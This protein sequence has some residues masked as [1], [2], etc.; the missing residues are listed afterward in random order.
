MTMPA[1]L[2]EYLITGQDVFPETWNL[3]IQW[4]L[5]LHTRML[6]IEGATPPEADYSSFPVG[7]V[8][9]FWKPAAQIPAGWQI[10]DGTN[11]TP[12]LR[13]F[14]IYGATDDTDLL[15][16]GGAET[17]VHT[18]PSTNSAGSHT[19]T[20]SGKTGGP[21]A[22]ASATAGAANVASPTHTHNY[23]FTTSSGGAHSHAV[24][25]TEAASSLPPYVKMYLITYMGTGA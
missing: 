14:F 4:L 13:A 20:A 22:T 24:A 17:H 23:S 9:P 21:S 16:T 8:V 6:A 15:G 10:C 2:P 19:H 12:D 5:Y 1:T 25:D 7:G 11:G 18:N 3:N